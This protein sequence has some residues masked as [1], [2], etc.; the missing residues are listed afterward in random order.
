MK[1]LIEKLSKILTEWIFSPTPTQT[2]TC[3]DR[4][5]GKEQKEKKQ[6]P[7]QGGYIY[8]S[9]HKCMQDFRHG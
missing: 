6:K 7:E 8:G 5:D 2:Y 9:S 3:R 4:E 1:N